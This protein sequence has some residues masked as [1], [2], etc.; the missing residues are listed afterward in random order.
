M[1]RRSNQAPHVRHLTMAVTHGQNG[2]Q[3]ACWHYV[4][5]NCK[6]LLFFPDALDAFTKGYP[7]VHNMDKHILWCQHSTQWS[8]LIWHHTCA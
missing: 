1:G 7:D 2:A 8:D 5:Q 6:F 4:S 3:Y